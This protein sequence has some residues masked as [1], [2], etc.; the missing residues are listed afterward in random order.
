ML[1]AIEPSAIHFTQF[2]TIRILLW[3]LRIL[4][5][6]FPQQLAVPFPLPLLI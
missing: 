1:T 2:L 5:N 3:R 6:S 4:A